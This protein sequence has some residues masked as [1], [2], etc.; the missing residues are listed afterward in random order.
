[1]NNEGSHRWEDIK[2]GD[3]DTGSIHCNTLEVQ[4]YSAAAD[5]VSTPKFVPPG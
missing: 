1:M 5:T 3:L 4:Q 2:D